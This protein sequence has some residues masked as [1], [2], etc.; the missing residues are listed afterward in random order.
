MKD[1]GK[2][3]K[4]ESFDFH[5]VIQERESDSES[6]VRVC[7]WGGGCGGRVDCSLIPVASCEI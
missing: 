5:P 4:D 6:R 2:T 7:V 3:V 1:N